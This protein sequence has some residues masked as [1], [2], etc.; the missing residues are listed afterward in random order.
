MG[1]TVDISV[2]KDRKHWPYLLGLGPA[3]L[4]VRSD[5]D[6]AQSIS[7]PLNEDS[8]RA[9]DRNIGRFEA[10]TYSVCETE[11]FWTV[12]QLSLKREIDLNYACNGHS[13]PN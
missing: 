8:D 3:L 2:A 4:L 13:S 1:G 9:N 10:Y 5:F 11:N 12:S 7:H 6:N